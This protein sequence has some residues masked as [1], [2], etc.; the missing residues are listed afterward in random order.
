MV[1]K[2]VKLD[3]KQWRKLTVAITRE[4]ARLRYVTIEDLLD[5]MDMVKH[6]VNRGFKRP[7]RRP[8]QYRRIKLL[9][10]DI[11]RHLMYNARFNIHGWW[12]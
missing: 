5:E 3:D 2:M 6:A 7:D 11:N 8:L 1:S 4:C 10:K 12:N 9:V